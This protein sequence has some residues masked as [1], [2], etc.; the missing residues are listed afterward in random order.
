MKP[1]LP[2]I[3][4]FCIS[5]GQVIYGQSHSF[6]KV[7][8]FNDNSIMNATIITN[9]G[10]L[11][12]RDKIKGLTFP[13]TFTTRLPDGTDV[14]DQVQ[15]VIRGKFR[16]SHC[17]LPPLKVIFNNNAAATLAPL[18]SLKLVSECLNSVQYEQY[19]L[20]EFII[21]KIYNLLT[22]ISFRVRLLNLRFQDSSGK[23]KTITEYAFLLEDLKD[24]A[25]RNNC[26]EWKKGKLRT[27]ATDRRQMTMVAIFEYMIGNTDWSVPVNHN[28]DLIS[29]KKDTMAR[30]L[31]VP[32]DFD[33]SG[34]V[35]TDYST[36]DEKLDIEKVE[37]RLYRGFP[38]TE[39][40]IYEVLDIFKQQKEKIYALIRSFD[41][42]SVT[43]KDEMIEYL[44]EFYYT[45]NQPGSVKYTF[46]ENAR[47]Q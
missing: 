22:D 26:K 21:Y 34:L 17:H 38:R 25:K 40:E 19:L 43:S 30:P 3:L 12:G 31:V 1:F 6:D 11:F 13:A 45:I 16:R 23:K 37:Q 33:F 7:E 24:M 9:T 8:F 4:L 14:K 46:I 35:N 27:E 32:Y 39:T 44:D 10:K 2:A 5:T 41:L 15:L 42:L 28:T 18:K 36:P 47:T 20:K 29:S